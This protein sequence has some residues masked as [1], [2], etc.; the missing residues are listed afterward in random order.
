MRIDTMIRTLL[1]TLGAGMALFPNG[2]LRGYERVAFENPDDATAK[3]WLPAAMR[4]EGVIYVLLCVLGGAAY[5]AF[6]R[7][8][9]GVGVVVACVPRRYL[10]WGGRLAYERPEDLRWRE[11]FVTA[12]RGLGILLVALAVR[13]V[14]RGDGAVE[15]GFEP[16]G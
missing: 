1:A 5:S 11:G 8:A 3:P 6:V 2:I 4:A 10:G 13:R 16:D 9:G 7:L 14:R 12:V 15:A